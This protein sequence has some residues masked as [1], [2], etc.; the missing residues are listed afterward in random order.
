M[1]EPWALSSTRPSAGQRHLPSSGMRVD[2]LLNGAL[3]MDSDFITAEQLLTALRWRYATK[4]FDPNRKIPA[5]LWSALEEALVLAPSS[6]GLQPYR[7]L[8]VD[9]PDLRQQLLPHAWNQRQVVDASHL[10]V[11][12][13]RTDVTRAEVDAYLSLTARIRGVSSESLQGLQR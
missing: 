3:T 6:F 7:F 2:S 4:V 13:A 1:P 5:D 8:V 9:D 12:A 10:V 11:F